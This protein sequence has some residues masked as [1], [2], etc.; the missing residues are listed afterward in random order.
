[1]RT[2]K[3]IALLTLLPAMVLAQNTPTPAPKDARVKRVV[4]EADNVV[5][6]FGQTFITT[7]IIF[8]DEEVVK[9]VEGGDSAGWIVDV[10][11]N[12]PNMVFIKPTVLGSNSNMTVVTNK[13]SYYFKI[14]SNQSLNDAA[15]K[16][17]YA[18]R[19][20]YPEEDRQRA[21]EA[22]QA[23]VGARATPPLV[24]NSR[25]FFNGSPAIRP[26]HVFDDG[27]FTYF[28]FQPNQAVPAIFSVDEARGSESVI[29]VRREGNYTVVQRLAPQFTLRNGR[30]VASIFNSQEIDR[31]RAAGRGR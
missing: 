7:H 31:L 12:L 23:A 21:K 5:P 1:M 22:R 28:E 10:K 20:R 2:K 26:L 4:Y 18:L 24:A 15:Y 17:T 16:P 27:R 29:N 30:A 3:M 25:Y 9:S 11:D 6:I 19:F 8:G 14:E 13:H